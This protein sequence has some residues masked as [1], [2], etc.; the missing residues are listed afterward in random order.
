VLSLIQGQAGV[1]Q[2]LQVLEIQIG[3]SDPALSLHLCH[4]PRQI[5]RKVIETWEREGL[6]AEPERIIL[7]AQETD[8]GALLLLC[9][10]SQCALCASGSPRNPGA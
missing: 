10:E 1:D 9:E 4:H 6:K 2:S 7:L 3:D 5:W 8:D